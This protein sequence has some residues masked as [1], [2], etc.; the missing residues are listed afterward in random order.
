[1]KKIFLSIVLLSL[2]IT[3][4]AQGKNVH[5]EYPFEVRPDSGLILF[6]SRIHNDSTLD[7]IALIDPNGIWHKY[8]NFSDSAY[9]AIIRGIFADFDSAYIDTVT[10]YLKGEADS[11]LLADSAYWADL[12]DG[13]NEDHFADTTE[14]RELSDSLGAYADTTVS[15]ALQDSLGAY[16]DT[17]TVL[18]DSVHAYQEA[19]DSLTTPKG[20]MDIITP[21]DSTNISFPTGNWYVDNLTPATNDSSSSKL[22]SVNNPYGEMYTAFI[23]SF[24]A[25]NDTTE[26]RINSGGYAEIYIDTVGT[27]SIIVE[28]GATRRG[29]VIE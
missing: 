22:G 5:V 11:A 25:R 23:Y 8:G 28:I 9:A 2:M 13:Y 6:T 12:L 17:N 3:V 19:T 29:V 21:K 18:R 14:L 15:N 10:G 20:K 1:M 7:T 16:L 4:C 27:D 24:L 26:L